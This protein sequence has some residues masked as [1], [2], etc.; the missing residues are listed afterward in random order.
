[1]YLYTYYILFNIFESLFLF[2]MHK[3]Q[4]ITC[5]LSYHLAF[6]F[7]SCEMRNIC[8]VLY[9]IYDIFLR[10]LVQKIALYIIDAMKI[11]VNLIL[12][13][14]KMIMNMLIYNKI[15]FIYVIFFT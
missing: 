13:K 5:K 2:L 11:S 8:F 15:L 3:I 12:Y 6:H 7:L 14:N 9:N 10:R 1:M 4:K